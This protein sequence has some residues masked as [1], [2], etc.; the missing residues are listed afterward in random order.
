ML[1]ESQTDLLRLMDAAGGK[2]MWYGFFVASQRFVD[3]GDGF[4]ELKSDRRIS[5]GTGA[6]AELEG[7]SERDDREVEMATA[8]A[9]IDSKSRDDGLS[10]FD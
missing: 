3:F 10:G 4:S 6:R 8:C 9:D 7:M 2:R 1:P 5:A